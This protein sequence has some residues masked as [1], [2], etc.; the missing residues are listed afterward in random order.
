MQPSRRPPANTQSV[1]CRH[2]GIHSRLH[3]HDGLA[4]APQGETGQLQMRPGE[5]N[6]NDGERERGRKVIQ[7]EPPLCCTA[8]FMKKRKIISALKPQDRA[9]YSS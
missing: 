3:R 7:G 2:K 5:W 9:A 1:W 8:I 4:N 6:A